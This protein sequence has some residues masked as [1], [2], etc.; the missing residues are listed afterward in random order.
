MYF[1]FY[2][3]IVYIRKEL[4]KERKK[5]CNSK[6]GTQTLA[7]YQFNGPST[8]TLVITLSAFM[9]FQRSQCIRSKP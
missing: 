5:R 9:Y 6:I 4:I 2:I 8:V 1:V 3:I 7:L